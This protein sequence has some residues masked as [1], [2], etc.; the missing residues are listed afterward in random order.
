MG[1]MGRCMSV[2]AFESKN[3]IYF[4]PQLRFCMP[5][6]VD[7]LMLYSISVLFANVLNC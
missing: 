3:S 2:E 1:T 7:L 5:G 6:G 4:V